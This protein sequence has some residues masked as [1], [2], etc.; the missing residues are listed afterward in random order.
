MIVEV[1]GRRPQCVIV[2]R[3]A[4][5]LAGTSATGNVGNSSKN[6][7]RLQ[8]AFSGRSWSAWPTA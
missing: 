2:V 8:Y 4:I 3:L 7:K 1:C 5:F 6:V